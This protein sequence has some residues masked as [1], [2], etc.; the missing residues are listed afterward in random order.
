MGVEMISMSSWKRN[1]IGW[2]ICMLAIFDMIKLH[3]YQ[4]GMVWMAIAFLLTDWI[5]E[6]M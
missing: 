4:L 6:N 2:A 5:E 3:D 1:L